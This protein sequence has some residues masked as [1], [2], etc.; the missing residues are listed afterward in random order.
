MSAALILV[1]QLVAYGVARPAREVLF[2]VISSEDKYRAEVV[3]DTV[4]QR[5]GDAAAAA[6]FGFVTSSSLL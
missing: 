2:T 1:V 6:I 4:V 3:L 5:V